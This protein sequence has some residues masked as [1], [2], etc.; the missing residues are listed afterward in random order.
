[1]KR[2]SQSYDYDVCLSFAGEDRD[3]VEEVASK[4]RERGIRVFYD[5]YEEIELWGKDL[6]THLD[7]VYRN[8]AR[9]CVLFISAAYGDKLWTSHELES[10]QA[11][12]F[13][14]NQEYM[15][16]A[17]FD[18]TSIPGLRTTVGYIDLRNR[19]AAELAE[20]IQAK[21][22]SPNRENYF[23]PHHDGLY[24]FLGVDKDVQKR[25]ASVCAYS[26]FTTLKRM[27]SDERDVIFHFFMNGC[28]ANLPEDIH[29]SQDLL[30]RVTGFGIRRLLRILSSIGSLGFHVN[31]RDEK[32]TEH[33]GH[34]KQF[35][36]V[37]H[38]LYTG[39]SK[40]HLGNATS[41][42]R[43]VTKVARRG[44]C[45]EHGIEQLRRL[46]F[47]MLSQKMASRAE[48]DLEKH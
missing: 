38:N 12:A 16:P 22:G 27:N 21:I 42:A 10:A 45:E 23:P 41:I 44:Y 3:Y 11:R 39:G 48:R 29:I 6:Y 46:D 28:P 20:M 31:E 36:L 35:V 30:S 5:R 13:E 19:T 4:L 40:S 33:L 17:R 24:E 1:M 2:D 14:A 37:W 25:K 8:T 18:D 15:L 43:A 34:G 7:D 32:N 47:S 26:F 9:Y